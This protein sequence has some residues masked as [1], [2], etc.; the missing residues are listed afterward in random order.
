MNL[1]YLDFDYSEDAEGT[2]TFDAMAS[3]PPAQIHALHAEIAGVLA[4]AHARWPDACGPLEEGCVWQFDL[5]GVREASTPL[6]L[7]FDPGSGQ[8]HASTG[9]S[10]S[11]RTTLTFTVSGGQEFCWALRDSLGLG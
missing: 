1:R 8:L 3:V 10:V 2:G 11:L 5:Q 7:K 6:V 9:T 4:W